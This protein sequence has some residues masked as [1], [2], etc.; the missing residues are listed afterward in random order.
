MDLAGGPNGLVVLVI[1]IAAVSGI[2]VVLWLLVAG[3]VD[4][5]RSIVVHA[6]VDR[7]WESIRHF[8]TLHARHGKARHLCRFEEWTLRRGDGERPGTIWR[9]SGIWD[10]D[11]YWADVEIVWTVPGREIALSLRRDSLGTHRGL[12]HHVGSLRLESVDAATTKLT[13][14]LRARLRS[15]RLIL[16]RLRA[17]SRLRAR[18]LDQG[19][20]SLKVE[21]DQSEQPAP[22]ETLPLSETPDSV[23]TAPLPPDRLPPETTV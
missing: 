20:R 3:R 7:A 13:W 14:R 4:S 2:L 5:S 22:G 11:Q 9:G 17:G 15:P 12:R 19:L 1:A 23:A 21:I 6:P 18:L 10:S 16:E 8:P